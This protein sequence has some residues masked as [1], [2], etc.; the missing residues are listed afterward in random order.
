[1]NVAADRTRTLLLVLEGFTGEEGVGAPFGHQLPA[2]RALVRGGSQAWLPGPPAGSRLAALGSLMTGAWP[3]QHGLLLPLVPSADGS[4]IRPVDAGDRERPAFWEMLDQQ[5]LGC[6]SVGWPAVAGASLAHGI[7]VD[8]A[9]GTPGVSPGKENLA[10][11]IVPSGEAPA[12]AECWM[13]P[14]ELDVGEL[15]V[16]VPEWGKVPQER[17]PR[18]AMVAGA[19]AHDVSRHAAFLELIAREGWNVASLVLSLPAELARI[20]AS[21]KGGESDCFAGLGERGWTLLDALIAA[22]L[23]ALPAGTRIM[24]AGLPDA[25]LPVSETS[26]RGFLFLHGPGIAADAVF[27]GASLLDMAP[28][29]WRLHGFSAP[30]VAGRALVEA[31]EDGAAPPAKDFGIPW[32]PPVSPPAAGGPAP[33][34]VWL[35]RWQIAALHLRAS[36]LMARGEWLSAMPL[37][38]RQLILQPDSLGLLMLLVECQYFAGLHREALTNAWDLL[39][40]AD[41]D[42]PLPL[43]MVAGLEATT[44]AFPTARRMLDDAAP[45]VEKRPAARLFQARV[46]IHLR[47]WQE[48]KTVLLALRIDEPGNAAALGLLA[49]AQL[50]LRQW[51]DACGSALQATSLNLQDAPTHEVL[52][53]A[54][55]KMGLKE[56]AWKAF[57]TA[58]RV[59][60]SWSRPWA[61]LVHLSRQLGRSHEEVERLTARYHAAG[62]AAR[63]KHEA[64]LDSLKSLRGAGLEELQAASTPTE[65]PAFPVSSA[66]PPSKIFGIVLPSGVDPALLRRRIADAGISLAAGAEADHPFWQP[67]LDQPMGRADLPL[68]EGRIYLMPVAVPPRLPKRHSYHLAMLQRDPVEIVN[69]RMHLPRH[70][71]VLDHEELHAALIQE[72]AHLRHLA[73]LSP[74]IRLLEFSAADFTSASSAGMRTLQEWASAGRGAGR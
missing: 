28:T 45:K 5:G 8:A 38:E 1:M 21:A 6:L 31:L 61:R 13:K 32:R 74:H 23:E 40:L 42:D 73:E 44:G 34:S 49:R 47:Q 10:R 20:E 26:P 19:V 57:A 35:T 70:L 9:F 46:L 72:R 59:T 52:G 17:D 60:P 66:P 71:A 18:L 37:L 36:S 3:D 68:D 51:T 55:L 62:T 2:L 12:L 24:I 15:A 54:L 67:L 4:A 39:E 14:E 25:G 63:K 11:C 65:R 7:A 50:G 22:I 56:E 69:E 27:N 53:M 64:Y 30:W 48:A 43:L 41:P 58:T 29:L 16:L 33:T